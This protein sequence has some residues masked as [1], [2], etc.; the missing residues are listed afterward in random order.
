MRKEIATILLIIIAVGLA[1]FVQARMSE[2]SDLEKQ[3]LG[4]QNQLTHYENL[5]ATLRNSTDE[6]QN[7]LSTLQ[8]QASNL[9]AQLHDLQDPVYNVT[10][11]NVTQ[12][13]WWNPVG[14]ALVK[15]ISFV[16]KNTGTRDVGG[17]TL[18]CELQVNGTVWNSQEYSLEFG[19]GG[20][21]GILHTQESVGMGGQILSNYAVVSSLV[22]KDFVAK[23]ML[24]NATLAEYVLPLSGKIY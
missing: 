8:T 6:L 9:Q 24:D 23:V 5:T 3:T 19:A 16:V 11:E 17:L 20:Q 7:S 18:V 12:G 14:I 2:R 13:S 10:I 21:L 22:A 15:D 4:L 1:Y